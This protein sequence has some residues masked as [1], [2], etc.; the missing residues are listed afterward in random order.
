MQQLS[1]SYTAW[2]LL[3]SIFIL[4]Q[5]YYS[6]MSC[7]Q[8]NL[9]GF[10]DKT[11]NVEVECLHNGYVTISWNYLPGDVASYQI[12]YLCY[13]DQIEQVCFYDAS[14]TS[15]YYIIFCYLYIIA[16]TQNQIMDIIIRIC[17]I[18]IHFS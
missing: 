1:S 13:S 14:I 12:A 15:H 2:F 6:M 11:I 7:D 18:Y 16:I 9:E 5:A 17:S 8:I 3:L 10:D 4:P